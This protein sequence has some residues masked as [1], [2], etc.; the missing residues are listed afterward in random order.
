MANIFDLFD[1]IKSASPAPAGPVT[2][3]V[4]GLGNPGAQYENTRH[5]AGFLAIDRI[6]E[7]AG[8][9]IGTAKCKGLVGDGMLGGRH[10]LLLKPQTYMNLSG[11]AVRAAVDFYHIPP[12]NVIVLCDDVNFDVSHVRI[13]LK[14]SHGGHNGLKS[15]AACLGSDAYTRIKIGVGHK[16]HPDYDLADWVLGKFSRED[17]TKLEAVLP[18]ISAAVTLLLEGKSEDAM[19]KYSH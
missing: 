15:I 6:A 16:P 8:I 3:L 11:D 10:V 14:G 12:E 1:K 17:L 13:R 18:D 9:R 2:H 7:Q 5:N 19:M 4:V